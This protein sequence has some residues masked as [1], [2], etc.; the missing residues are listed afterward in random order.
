MITKNKLWMVGCMLGLACGNSDES[1]M[2]NDGGTGESGSSG[3]VS[4][5]GATS[6]TSG[7]TTMASMSA[8]GASEESS[9]DSAVDGPTSADSGTSAGTDAGSSS[10]GDGGSGSSS[11][12]GLTSTSE[13]G[14]MDQCFA[15][16]NLTPCDAMTD[17]P[18]QAIGLN[19]PGGPDEMIPLMNASFSSLDPVAWR[20]ARQ[21]GSGLDGMGVPL[22]SPR[23]GEQF[24]LLSS[25][26]IDV[27]DANGV[28]TMDN[29]DVYVTNGN[30]DGVPMPVP[31]SPNDGSNNGVGGTPFVN[32]NG[33][34]D[35]SDTLEAQ[36][37]LGGGSARDQIWFQFETLVPGGTHGFTFDFAY[38]SVE[39]PEYVNSI[40]NDVFLVWSSSETYTGNL[41]FVNDQPCTV[42]ALCNGDASCANLAYC[43]WFTCAN[44]P[45]PELEGTGFQTAGGGTGW[46]EAKASAEPN[47]VLQVTW[48][49]FDMGDST[50]DTLVIVDDWRWDCEGCI[51]S[52]VMGCSITPT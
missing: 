49:L 48:T 21:L 45:S 5:T 29:A 24:L 22:W 34:D 52:E 10:L 25:G 4:M 18:F 1:A 43:N 38:F 7:T 11:I 13:S 31:I 8:T 19:C 27:P 46:F 9:G 40:Y 32:C 30:P 47:E 26:F 51:P 6:R 15:P 39:F 41:C 17:D 36:W 42:T 44:P 16:G 37:L 14:G 50:L 3:A 2:V 35:C 12:S 23:E 28:I 33:I 20:I